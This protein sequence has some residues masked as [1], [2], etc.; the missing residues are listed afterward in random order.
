[1]YGTSNTA[2]L[3]ARILKHLALDEQE[4][5]PLASAVTITDVLFEETSLETNK[6]FAKAIDKTVKKKK[7]EIAKI[8]RK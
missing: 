4:S 3:A 5:L 7:D 6:N 1:M 8:A 2:Y